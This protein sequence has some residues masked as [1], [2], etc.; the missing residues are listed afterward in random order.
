MA[1]PLASL[2]LAIAAAQAGSP[3]IRHAEPLAGDAAPIALASAED[4]ARLCR[5]LI[6]A[7]RVR[8]GGDAIARGAAEARHAAERDEALAR[9]YRVI[10]P[11]GAL[12]FESYDESGGELVLDDRA[13]L[14]VA[15][16]A[17]RVWLAEEAGL[18]VEVAPAVAKRILEA[19][20][21]GTLA[22]ALDFALPE[23][24]TC[25]G[26]AA[27]TFALAAEPV[28]WR[29][30]DGDAPLAGGG[31]EAGRGLGLVNARPRVE[32]G[33]PLQGPPEAR[34]AVASRSADLERCYADA[35]ART[36][37]IDGV[38][39]ARLG[40]AGGLAADSVGDAGL[41]ECVGRAVGSVAGTGTVPIRFELAEGRT[42][43][44]ASR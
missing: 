3:V 27:R 22:L 34:A 8:A 4:V 19:Q 9:R 24:A 39:V 14:P 38:L 25:G 10:V 5:A 29:W 40:G 2:V 6:P 42:G 43:G 11:G 37:G 23:D 32:I 33:A 28:G 21:R 30:L 13:P 17:A 36:P 1:G 31:T 26:G 20:A 44:Q 35:L 16:G 7:E 41:A 12:R 15:K 18:P